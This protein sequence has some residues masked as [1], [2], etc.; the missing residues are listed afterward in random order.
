[1]TMALLDGTKVNLGGRDF[2]VPPLNLKAL[3]RLAPTISALADMAD[4]PTPEQVGQIAEVVHAAVVRNY[5]EITVDEMEELLDLGN[6]KA[7][8]QAILSGSGL[9]QGEP[10]GVASSGA[11]TG[12]ASTGS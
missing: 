1:M 8:L 11:S 12:P 9:T 7:V 10:G 4:V 2:T 6:I 5:P 3:R